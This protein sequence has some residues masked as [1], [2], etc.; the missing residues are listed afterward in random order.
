MPTRGSLLCLAVLFVTLGIAVAGGREV[1]IKVKGTND[2]V[3]PGG[4]GSVMVTLKN[5]TS[6]S[7][8]VEVALRYQDLDDAE[9]IATATINLPPKEK[10]SREFDVAVPRDWFDK[11]LRVVAS[12]ADDQAKG[13]IRTVPGEF[14]DELWL[15]G[16]DLFQ[17]ECRNCHGGNG[18][19]IRN[20]SLQSWIT[21]SRNGPGRMPR[22][23]HLTRSDFVLMYKYAK[24]AKR[25][26]E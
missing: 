22:Y 11:R 14:T 13:K 4:T 20:D 9:P 15:Q 3:E 10:V 1:R 19:K 21:N 7:R 26:V 2:R 12:T 23:P 5:R 18:W 6:E 24:D 16:R 17:Q 25:Q 8:Q